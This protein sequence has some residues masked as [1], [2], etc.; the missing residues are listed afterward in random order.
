MVDLP[1][2]N[3]WTE[4]SSALKAERSYRIVHDIL[5]T[6]GFKA[7]GEPILEEMRSLGVTITEYLV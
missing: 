2:S 4:H 3:I 7:L 5:G 6:P 1:G